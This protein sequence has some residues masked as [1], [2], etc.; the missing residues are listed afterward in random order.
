MSEY[1]KSTPKYWCKHCKTHVRDTP[2]EKRNHEATPR[3]QG[4]IS[5]FLRDLHRSNDREA[6]DAQRAKDEAARLNGVAGG[7][8]SSGVASSGLRAG[9]TGSSGGGG[10]G[11]VGAVKATPE[12]R[13]RQ[14]AQLAAMGV[15]VPEEYRRENA[16]VGEW[17]SARVEKKTPLPRRALGETRV[18]SEVKQ[19]EEVKR[20]EGG[21]GDG[22][23]VDEVS[24]K[25]PADEEGESVGFSFKGKKRPNWGTDTK[26]Y[27]GGGD[28][29]LDALLSSTVV[30][31]KESKGQDGD[32]PGSGDAEDQPNTEAPKLVKE[33][34]E[35][36]DITA[37]P[38]DGSTTMAEPKEAE[39][40][41]EPDL[42]SIFK[43][44]KVKSTRQ[45]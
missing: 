41:E 17:E 23:G 13:K 5:R 36:K 35:T 37:A 8:S 15:A 42:G 9:G 6:R 43:K 14:L 32:V 11:G 29:E 20:E 27:K 26:K 3:H 39:D 24:R 28:D 33:E 1:W 45:K 38:L 10:G 25:R 34:S 18:K 22:L 44:R 21:D 12:E 31:K 30:V 16:M 19:E 7:D 4:N 2:L 40:D